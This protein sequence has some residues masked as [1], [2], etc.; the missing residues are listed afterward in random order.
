MGRE[1]W[2]RIVR[3]GTILS[4]CALLWPGSDP[5]AGRD[6]QGQRTSP[7]LLTADAS[8]FKRSIRKT[9]FPEGIRVSYSWND[10]RG[11]SRAVDVSVAAAAVAESERSFGFS[12]DELKGFLK[13]AEAR[14]RDDI[15]LSAVDIARKVVAGSGFE[16]CQVDESPADDFQ[17]VLR[18]ASSGRA[19]QA[20]EIDRIIAVSKKAWESSQKK[21]RARLEQEMKGFLGSRGMLTTP[22]GIA[23]DYKK[24]VR[25][26]RV[27]LVPLAE[28]FKRVCGPNKKKL[29]EAVLSFVQ[30]IPYRPRPASED[31]K[32]TAGMAVP[33]RVLADDSGDCDSKAV[34]FASLWTTLCGHRTILIMVRGH[35]LVGVAAPF[36]TGT[37]LE[38][39]GIRYVLLEVNCG[40]SLPPGEV[41]AY[42]SDSI[43]RGDLKYRIVS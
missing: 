43:A 22:H 11:V 18:T 39:D 1:I 25:Q 10:S 9:P 15:G 42:S 29:L 28:E 36:A 20:A 24:L 8:S 19:G 38:L 32:Y 3:A 30:G 23:A 14:I 40:G 4:V 26:N 17:F 2:I 5:G 16:W 7:G 12:C 6:V 27:R 37:T 41:S 35:M 21:V 34:L 31:G 13:D 33:L